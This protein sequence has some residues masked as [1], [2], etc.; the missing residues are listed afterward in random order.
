M[1]E[2][3]KQREAYQD[4]GPSDA[5]VRGWMYL[6]KEQ[7]EKGNTTPRAVEVANFGFASDL[8]MHGAHQGYG[9][10]PHFQ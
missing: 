5:E 1:Y 2:K 7:R 4:S 8:N 10:D 9:A 6:N 3:K